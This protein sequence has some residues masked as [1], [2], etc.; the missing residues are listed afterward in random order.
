[1]PAPSADRNLLF[2]IL[3]YQ[4]DFIT[5]LALL[6][7]LRTWLND[8]SKPVDVRLREAGALAADEHALVAALVD[9]HLARHG[10]D[11]QRSLAALSSLD[12]AARRELQSLAGADLQ[13]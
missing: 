9:R 10:G 2:G 3:A 4:N 11:P 12:P 8:R 1:M 7:A 6:D 13:A 5:L